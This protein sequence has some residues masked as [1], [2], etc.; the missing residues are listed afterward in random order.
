MHRNPMSFLLHKL[1][2]RFLLTNSPD[3][4]RKRIPD[5]PHFT[6]EAT[7]VQSGQ[8]TCRRSQSR[9]GRMFTCFPS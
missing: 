6:D 2:F 5:K 8:A 9:G 7:E 3:R 1:G 4:E